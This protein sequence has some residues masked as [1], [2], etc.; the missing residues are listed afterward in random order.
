MKHFLMPDNS[1]VSVEDDC[2]NF[3]TDHS[4]HNAQEITESE[5]EHEMEKRQPPK[6]EPDYGEKRRHAYPEWQ[7]FADA[8][9]EDKTGR[10]EKML[11]YMA[12]IAAIKKRFPKE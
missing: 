3:E 10:P 12:K 7:E 4:I 2:R 6:R 5:F 8:F 1:I 9:V 11:E